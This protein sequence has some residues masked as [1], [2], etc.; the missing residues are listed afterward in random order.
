VPALLEAYRIPYT[1][2][3]P[4]TL[5]L[6][7]DK[8]LTKRIV[9]SFGL[10]T[11]DFALVSGE[12]DIDTVSMSMPLFVKPVAEGTAKGITSASRITTPREL[13]DAC[14]RLLRHFEQ[15]VLVEEYLPGREFTVGIIGTGQSAE[16]VGTMEI[17]PSAKADAHAYTYRNKEHSE[18]LIAYEM[19][20]DESAL[21]AQE[22]AL[23][24]WRALGCRDA[25][26]VDL[27]EDGLG[28]VQFIEANPLAGLHPT[29][30]DLPML[31]AKTGIDFKELIRRIVASAVQRWQECRHEP[32]RECAAG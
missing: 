25:G 7:L 21:R 5:A 13:G 1:F 8:A 26:R 16:A 30:S 23:A 15:P 6:T 2:S 20:N 19:A 18:D 12:A 24:A 29:H 22:V 4:L 31:C 17:L 11:P 9:R 14:R 10:P 32:I 28:S 3:D 27:R